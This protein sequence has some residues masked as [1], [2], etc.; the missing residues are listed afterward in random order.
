MKIRGRRAEAGALL[1]D[2]IWQGPVFPAVHVLLVSTVSTARGVLKVE[3][4]R[5]VPALAKF[6]RTYA[7]EVAEHSR[8]TFEAL[9]NPNLPLRQFNC[10]VFWLEVAHVPSFATDRASRCVWPSAGLLKRRS[11]HVQAARSD[12]DVKRSPGNEDMVCAMSGSAH[13]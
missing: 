3:P 2:Q 11:P 4:E 13:D 6:P 5:L 12:R 9:S 10:D 8:E 1:R 7:E